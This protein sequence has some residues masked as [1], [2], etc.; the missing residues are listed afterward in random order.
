MPT[1][2]YSKEIQARQQQL[3]GAG[4]CVLSFMHISSLFITYFKYVMNCYYKVLL[5]MKIM[6][7]KSKQLA[8]LPSFNTSKARRETWSY[9]HN[10]W[11]HS[12]TSDDNWGWLV[13]VSSTTSSQVKYWTHHISGS[14]EKASRKSIHIIFL[15]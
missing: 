11:W 6:T 9:I 7:Q 14:R 2:F 10:D 4:F 5:C 1:S 12:D 13:P 15:K 3:V 8:E